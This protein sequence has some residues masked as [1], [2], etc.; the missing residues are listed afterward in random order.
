[1]KNHYEKIIKKQYPS[2][3]IK[4]WI[5]ESDLSAEEKSRMHIALPEMTRI[6][7]NVL[8]NREKFQET[9]P[10]TEVEGRAQALKS[11]EEVFIDDELK[12]DIVM[13]CAIPDL[14]E[15][16]EPAYN[17]VILFG[18]PG[19]GKT[20]LLKAIADVYE[21]SGAYS[22]EISLSEIGSPFVGQFARNLETE[23]QTALD[24]AEIRRR[25]SFLFFDEGSNLAQNAAEGA[26]SVSKHY[27][28]AID[29]LK[30]YL[31]N[32][33]NL[34][35]AISTNGLPESFEQA[36]TREGRLTSFFIGYPDVEQRK[37]M[38]QHFT[39]KHKIIELS[40]TQA[41]EL[42]E[43]T[44]E[45]QGA[46]IEEFTR[47]YMRTRRT[48]LLKRNGYA[49]L[50]EALKKGARMGDEEVRNTITYDV[51]RQNILEAIETKHSRSR[52]P[53]KRANPIGFV[54]QYQE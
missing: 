3:K 20:V 54:S 24:D 17:G 12:D 33:R 46:F 7:R 53:S 4:H 21:S 18:P 50:V 22:K 38:W 9:R 43:A 15:G 8:S 30:R 41:Y 29:V 44:P 36:L 40:D 52:Q 1:M 45:E 16:E 2:Y 14:L 51:L 35:I 47:N 10:G 11:L 6:A 39:R 27:Q 32:N 42:A 26:S 48:I 19:T 37:R 49:N 13:R 28:E 31:G 23:I 25:P 34:V 5:D